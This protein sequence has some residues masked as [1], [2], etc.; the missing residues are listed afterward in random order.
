MHP[1]R[2]S[3][4]AQP[5][6]A[7]G[8]RLLCSTSSPARNGTPPFPNP[9]PPSSAPARTTPHPNSGPLPP[10]DT[11]KRRERDVRV[12]ECVRPCGCVDVRMCAGLGRRAGRG[13]CKRS[14]K[15]ARQRKT[16]LRRARRECGTRRPYSPPLGL[17]RRQTGRSRQ[18]LVAGTRANWAS[19]HS[20]QG[21]CTPTYLH[22]R[23]PTH[24][25]AYHPSLLAPPRPSPPRPNPSIPILNVDTRV[26][27]REAKEAAGSKEAASNGQNG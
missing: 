19:S 22:L 2:P 6:D 15:S 25:D 20:Q 11:A 4:Q 7:T 17:G 10:V 27:G 9:L 13:Q 5:S 1:A 23:R 14:T 12:L 16:W 21:W 26:G 24:T 3:S 18:A 8:S